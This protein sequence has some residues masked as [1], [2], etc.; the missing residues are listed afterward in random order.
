MTSWT[1][2]GEAPLPMEFSRQEYWGGQPFLSPKCLHGC[3]FFFK[4]IYLVI[5]DC[6]GSLLLRVGFLQLRCGQLL[7]AAAPPVEEH[8]PWGA[9][10]SVCRPGSCSSGALGHRLSS[11]GTRG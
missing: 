4:C 7:I 3:K 6:A 10:A 8:S 5:F 1:V 11:C 2:T 9:R